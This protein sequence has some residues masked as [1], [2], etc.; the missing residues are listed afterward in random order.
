M[1]TIKN[2]LSLVIPMYNEAE[3]ITLATEQIRRGVKSK[4]LK[5]TEVVFVDDGSTDKTLTKIRQ[6]SRALKKEL[7]ISVKIIT[8]KQNKGKGFAVRRG[9][10]AT[11]SDYILL[12]DVD[13][14]TPLGELAKLDP[15]IHKG[16]EVIIG[17]RKN[18]EST[19]ML[20]QPK[21]RQIMGKVFTKMTQLFLNVY[22]TD[23]TCGFKLFSR[24]SA[25]VIFA[26]SRVDRWGYDAEIMF[27][28][29]KYGYSIRE[30]ALLWY[31]DDRTNVR[32]L[33]AALQTI[34]E[35]CQIR[36]YDLRGVYSIP[37]ERVTLKG[38]VLSWQ[39]TSLL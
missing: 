9:M 39:T 7:G 8:Y 26:N 38:K 23:F 30:K 33:S 35:L 2:T 11:R 37:L 22:V 20:A 13:M 32:I 5:L 12:A 15:Y 18:G 21:Y 6:Y 36:L 19:V 10:L 34:G 28:A 1:K 24:E 29:Q 27:L 17:T 31:N 25:A 16:E 3:R 4:T 14:S